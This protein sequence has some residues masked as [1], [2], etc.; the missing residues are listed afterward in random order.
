M[1]VWRVKNVFRSIALAVALA[2]AAS[3]VQAQ[4]SCTTLGETNFVR[5]TLQDIYYW[6]RNLSDPNPAL[7]DSPEAYLEAVRYKPLD[8]SFSYITQ[9]ASSD[10]FFSDSQFIGIGV[11]N[12]LLDN[13][14][15]RVA[16]VFPESPASE[17]GLER[18][19]KWL[20]IAGRTIEDYLAKGDL[21]NAFGATEIG[22][23]VSVRFLDNTGV[24][25]SATL[26]KRLV[27]I[28]TVSMTQVYDLDGKKVGYIH[29]RNF[30]QPSVAA[31]DAAFSQLQAQGA[32]ELI[33]DERY[34][35]GGL[36]SVAQ[37][38]ASLIGGGRTSAKT[39]CQFF[40]NDKNSSR[41]QTLF[42]QYPTNA[43]SLSRLVV[44]TTRASASASEL[45]INALR[46]FL[47]VTLVGDTTYGKPVGQYGYNFCDKVLYPVAFTLRNANG[48]GDFFGGFAPDCPAA[49][50]IDHL[51]GD[52]AEASLGEAL[53]YLRTGACS[54]GARGAAV[55]SA[56]RA[57]RSRLRESGFQQ[58]LGAY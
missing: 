52:P 21:G 43:L 5:T 55:A 13:G 36:V 8:T 6:Y 44:I 46:P 24:E 40:H 35:G 15:Y 20:E 57:S 12:K 48:E 41:N 22:V 25:K 49:D 16:Q 37:Y 39:F 33:L 4:T 26:T 47:K 32:S 31:L 7:F 30:V 56:V 17:A 58:L 34:N 45:V 11:S 23:S 29:F 9:R 10:A 2:A 54:A 14:D 53:T 3:S 18:G 28:P 27:T 19:A 51:F 38:L 1:G 42:F 50:D